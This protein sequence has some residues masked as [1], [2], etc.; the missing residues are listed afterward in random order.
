MTTYKMQQLGKPNSRGVYKRDIGKLSN[1]KPA[2]FYVGKYPDEAVKRISRLEDLWRT[3]EG[4]GQQNW[5]DDTRAIGRA[6]ARGDATVAISFDAAEPVGYAAGIDFFSFHFGHLITI[7]PD[8]SERYRKGKTVEK[9]CAE[10]AIRVGQAAANVHSVADLTEFETTTLHEAFDRYV[11]EYIKTE[12]KLRD[13]TTGD[14]TD[15]GNAQITMAQRQKGAHNDRPLHEIKLPE[16][17]SM[18]DHWRARPM[19]KAKGN[20]KPQPI[21]PSTVKHHIW[22]L[23]HFFQWV[24]ENDFRWSAPSKL[25]R[26]SLKCELTPQEKSELVTPTQV[27][28][29]TDEELVTIYQ[30]AT[31][32]ERV[33]FLLGLNCGFAPA[34]FGSLRVN[35]IYLHQRHG[36]DKEVKYQSN[37]TQSWIKRIRIK[38]QV[39]GEW[40]LWDHTVMALGWA[41]ARR[42][43]MPTFS[44]N[45]FLMLTKTGLPYIGQ[46]KGGNHS[47]KVYSM[48]RDKLLKRVRLH[49]HDFRTLPPKS[50]RKTSGNEIR[51]IADGE[52]QAV[53]LSHGQPVKSDDL[54]EIYSN[55]PFRKVFES[56]EVYERR[57]QPLWDA[58]PDPFPTLRTT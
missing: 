34:E 21:A 24:D 22:Q 30:H 12:P 15:W 45:S 23:K 56:L 5:T 54:A 33:F 38:N 6:I 28:T 37:P 13:V 42:K 9:R 39:Y 26:I 44:P 8:D 27:D 32:L 58:V 25:D 49:E 11:E 36:R 31:E 53:H 19:V 47:T 51:D 29:W 40:L 14:L 4:L 3:V 57:L 10:V 50:L 41:L 18:C 20:Q 48:W 35:E 2:R 17:K 1:G 43:R 16:I 46:T 52:V 55:R 7:L